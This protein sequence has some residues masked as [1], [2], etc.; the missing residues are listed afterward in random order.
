M[1]TEI[2]KLVAQIAG[3]GG[4]AFGV[5]L[6]L[7][8]DIIRKRIFPRLDRERGYRL[9]RLISLLTWSIALAGI[10]AWVWV[11][12]VRSASGLLIDAECSVASGGD[13][14]AGSI[15]LEVSN[16]CGEGERTGRD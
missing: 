12:T 9:L 5:F 6:L 3:I 4:I 14:N 2:L 11:E 1:D 10:G 15:T 13:I 8:R 16:A 7:F